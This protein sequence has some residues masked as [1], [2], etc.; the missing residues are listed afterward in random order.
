[1]IA[2]V[3][4]LAFNIGF[5]IAKSS[6]LFSPADLNMMSLTRILLLS[7]TVAAL[8]FVFGGKTHEHD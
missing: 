6:D 4:A 1:M 8:P 2:A 7:L 3:L 5:Y